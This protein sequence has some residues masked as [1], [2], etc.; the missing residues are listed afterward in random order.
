MTN[1]INVVARIKPYPE[2]FDAAKRAIIEIIDRTRA[3]QGCITFRLSEDADAGSLHLY[4]E[5]RDE[6]ALAAHHE[7]SYTKGVFEAYK[8]WLAEEPQILH[9]R[10]VR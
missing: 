2:Y 1:Q 6:E 5:W 9:L 10:P 4:E 3:E 7:E 8:S